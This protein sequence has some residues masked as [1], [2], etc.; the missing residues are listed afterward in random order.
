MNVLLIALDRVPELSQSD[1][2]RRLLESTGRLDGLR[3]SDLVDYPAVAAFKR[4]VLDALF[5]TFLALP[6]TSPRRAAFE[7][8]RQAGGEALERHARFETIA[9]AFARS[10]PGKADWRRWPMAFRSPE[11]AEIEAFAAEH[12]DR[13]TFY[14]WLQWLA[15]SQLAQAQEQATG[16]GAA[17]GLYLDLAVGAAPDGAEAWS[18][19]EALVADVRIG[20]PPDDFNP[21]GQN[22][23]LLP[24][25]PTTLQA[26]AYRPFIQLLRRNMRHAG[27]LRIDHVLGLARSFWQPADESVPGAYIRYPMEDLLGIVALESRRQECVV[28]GEDLGTVPKELRS[29]LDRRGLLG[30]RLLYFEREKDGAFKPAAA[31]PKASIA[32]TGTHDLP[33]LRGFWEGRDIQVRKD[34]GMIAAPDQAGSEQAARRA[35]RRALLTLLAEEGL[36]PEHVVPEDPPGTL[37]WPLVLALHAFLGRT[38]AALRALQLEDAVGA[39]EQA[40]LPGTIDA[41]PNWRRKVGPD[42]QRLALDDR[43]ALLLRTMSRQAQSTPQQPT[44]PAPNDPGDQT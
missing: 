39:R 21:S 41:Y 14:A 10:D 32:S 4:E 18:D 40:N 1:R 25:S 13:V 43:L 9:E 35:T 28:I 6:Q 42:L 20:A 3:A 17:L 22:W 34:L 33:T 5:E 8:F 44:R 24:L 29:A 27:A 19:Q 38:P 26:R 37:S 7:Q 15:A 16:A 30:C 2:A 31:Y 12:T 11:S 23:G 36:L